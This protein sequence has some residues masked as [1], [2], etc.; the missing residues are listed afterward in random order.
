MTVQSSTAG[1]VVVHRAMRE[2]WLWH[3]KPPHFKVAIACLLMANWRDGEWFT[4]NAGRVV[5]PR[6]SFVTSL[7]HL[8]KEA[9]V[10]VSQVR[11]ALAHLRQGGFIEVDAGRDKSFTTIS[12][13]N[14]RKYQDPP[15]EFASVSAS[16]SQAVSTE[17]TSKSRV[18]DESLTSESQQQ[19]KNN[20]RTREQDLAAPPQGGLFGTSSPSQQKPPA[21]K[22]TAN[23]EG[24]RK[25]PFQIRD[26]G[27]A[28]KRGAGAKF[29]A[30]PYD[31]NLNKPLTA[32]IRALDGEGLGLADVEAAGRHVATWTTPPIA[33][34]WL[35]RSGNL[36][37]AIGKARADR[38]P[39]RS[40]NPELNRRRLNSV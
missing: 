13:I 10:S 6:G 38:A 28:F 17:S 32:I 23:G 27:E 26:L 20:K 1:F 39:Q 12:V 35:A 4:P 8:A 11:T 40:S 24:K 33:W 5:V 14:Y 16:E 31:P 25:L 34:N 18:V 30:E 7:E 19:N 37:G 21:K 9:R 22:H 29:I 3:L 2:S 15:Q 36:F